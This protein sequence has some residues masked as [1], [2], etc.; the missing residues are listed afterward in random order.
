MKVAELLCQ[1]SFSSC[2]SLLPSLPSF[3]CKS[4][5]LKTVEVCGGYFNCS[6]QSNGTFSSFVFTSLFLFLIVATFS[7]HSLFL[8]VAGQ[9]V[10][11]W[12][13]TAYGIIIIIIML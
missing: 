2:S 5:C 1:T 8:I 4:K 10:W 13:S 9:D 3:P 12:D 6:L 7:F 11:P